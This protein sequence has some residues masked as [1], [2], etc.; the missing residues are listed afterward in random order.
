MRANRY[1]RY[2]QPQKQL[3]P[4][5]KRCTSHHD[6]STWVFEAHPTNADVVRA[7]C[8]VCQGYIGECPRQ[9][10]LPIERL[11]TTEKPKPKPKPRPIAAPCVRY[12]TH[13][14]SKP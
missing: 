13:E 11:I 12:V 7:Y 10:T 9:A 5:P 2:T 3:V 8:R 4:A 14:G 6:R 1:S